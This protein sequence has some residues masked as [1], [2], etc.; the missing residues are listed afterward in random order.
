MSIHWSNLIHIF[1]YYLSK[2]YYGWFRKIMFL[3]LVY[4]YNMY[5][6]ILLPLIFKDIKKE[7]ITFEI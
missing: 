4:I 6:K 2:S 5:L 3:I 7:L 1:F